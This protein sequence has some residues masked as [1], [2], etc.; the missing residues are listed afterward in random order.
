[1]RF[2]DV[3]QQLLLAQ[4]SGWHAF[5]LGVFVTTHGEAGRRIVVAKSASITANDVVI[6]LIIT[7]L[8]STTRACGLCGK[9][10]R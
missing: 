2:C 3:A 8:D 4:Q 5:S 9:L 10:L 7:L 1:V 6:L